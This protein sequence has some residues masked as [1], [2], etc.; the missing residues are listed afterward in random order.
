[1]QAHRWTIVAGVVALGIAGAVTPVRAAVLCRKKSGVVVMR[2]ACKKKEAPIDLTQFGAIGPQGPPG[3]PGVGPLTT[4]PPD[5]VLAGPTCIDKFEASVWKIPAAATDVIAKVKAGTATLTDLGDAGAVQLGCVFP[6]NHTAYP[7]AFPPMGNFTEPVYVA[8]I[9]G[10]LPSGCASPLQAEQA[11]AL[12]GKRLPTNQE[13]QR[14]VV[15]TPDPGV[16]DGA[17]LC[18][19]DSTD[20]S[21]TG[22]RAA[23]VSKWGAFD[24]VGNVWEW[25]AEWDEN[26]SDCDDWPPGAV[27]DVS[28]F[29]GAAGPGGI[30]NLPR[31]LRRGGQRDTGAGAGVLA[32]DVSWVPTDSVPGIGFRCAR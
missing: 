14:A 32:V 25:V 18:N 2:D 27:M 26:A 24:M 28:C 11:C 9:A 21:N 8:S 1:M 12:S 7:E 15:G 29:G 31:V 5:M 22:S 19:V 6:H 10:V 30:D 3:P 13:W 17:T 16:D 20:Q 4:C 23:C